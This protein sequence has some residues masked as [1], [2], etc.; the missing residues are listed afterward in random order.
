MLQHAKP[1]QDNNVIM[2]YIKLAMHSVHAS[3]SQ[4]LKS[5]E[6]DSSH[7]PLS[8]EVKSN[9]I[10]STVVDLGHFSIKS[11]HVSL[12]QRLAGLFSNDLV[13]CAS[14]FTPFARDKDL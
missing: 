13:F 7:M 12:P 8:S 3:S 9:V 11:G 14:I 6:I 5:F 1:A 10:K 4:L 2:L